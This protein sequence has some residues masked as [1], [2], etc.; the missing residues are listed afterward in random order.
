[1]N[2]VNIAIALQKPLL[3]KGEPGTGKTMLAQSIA[4]ALGLKLIIWNIKST[5]KAQEGLYVYDTVQR[6]YDSQ[7]GEGDVSDIKQYIKLGKLGEA[8]VSD[9]QV[10]LLIDEIDKADLEFPNDLL[11]ELDQMSFYIP[12]TKETITA[13]HRPIVIITSNAEKE[14]P[15]AFLR[16][17][18]FHYI[19][20]PAPEEMEKIVRVHH[21]NI[22]K[23]LLEQAMETFYMLRSIPNIQ[24][25]PSTSELIDW[26][27]ALVVGGI[28]P[29]KIKQDLPF[30]GVLL[31]K[32]ED[33]DLV[34]NEVYN[35]TR[36]KNA[37][38]T[39]IGSSINRFRV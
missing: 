6:L 4:D 38:S 30:L 28:K 27:Q 1:M 21:P 7:F 31:K 25:K 3:L 32:N 16:R 34:L 26:L 29:S 35:K 24:K 2:S 10:V 14:L 22:E 39:Y 12:E 36:N 15:D 17:C 19:A 13:K 5:T 37:N 8:F 11:W 20:F 18:I 33:L 23:K 9:E